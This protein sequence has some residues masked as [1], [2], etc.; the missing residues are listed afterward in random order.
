MTPHVPTKGEQYRE[1]QKQIRAA[2]KKT[3]QANPQQ[4]EFIEVVGDNSDLPF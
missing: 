3:N 2:A 1:L 4:V